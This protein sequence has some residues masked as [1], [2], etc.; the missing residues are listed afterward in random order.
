MVNESYLGDYNKL[1][2][3]NV[4]IPM[5]PF[6]VDMLILDTDYD[7]YMS[8]YSCLDFVFPFLPPKKFE[9]GWVFTREPKPSKDVVK[10]LK[11]KV[12]KVIIL[13]YVF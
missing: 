12:M 5:L 7:S 11:M 2:H 3:I 10:L 4:Q 1:Y 9:L 13:K 8:V 6:D